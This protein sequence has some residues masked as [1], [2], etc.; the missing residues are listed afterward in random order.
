MVL[1]LVSSAGMFLFVR[2]RSIM[3]T[4][5]KHKLRDTALL[6]AMQFTKEE[7]DQIHTRDDMAKPVFKQVI[8]RLRGIRESI[9][10]IQYVY[11]MRRTDHP[12]ILHFIADADSLATDT[13]LDANENGT[14]DVYEMA[15][16]PGDQYDVSEVPALQGDA[17][18][19]PTVDEEIAT[20]Q[21]GDSIS[22]YAPILSE[23]G[24]AVAVLGVDMNPQEFFEL[25][26]SIFSPVALLLL[27]LGAVFLAAFVIHFIWQRKVEALREIDTHRSAVMDLTLHQLGMPLAIFKWWLE[28]FKD[29]KDEM[30]NGDDIY[31]QMVEG[32]AR[33]DS[34]MVALREANEV[35]KG[36][37]IYS[38]EIASLKELIQKE[39]AVGQNTATVRHQTI[40]VVIDP[41]L[42]IIRL[43]R[44]LIGG[45]LREVL[46]NAMAYSPKGTTI[47]VRAT[48]AKDHVQVEVQDSGVGIPVVDLPH[49]F[50]KFTRASNATKMK[51]VGNGLGLYTARGIIERAGGKMWIESKEGQGSTLFFTLPLSD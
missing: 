32:V 5:L 3:E 37:I 35:R 16:Y 7:L 28:I 21:W 26:H 4:Q 2:S 24:E 33:M 50:E 13:E 18:L 12:N 20:D 23:N 9:P 45:V 6:G 10:S 17:F 51:A 14:V 39:V 46:D 43:D 42:D 31:A 19:Q 48:R 36:T 47:T 40:E 25:S 29:H 1:V 44:K 49:I 41:S 30:K 11:I 38:P 15:S 27:L 34:I 22:G 8:R